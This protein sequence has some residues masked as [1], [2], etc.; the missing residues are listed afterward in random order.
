M[1]V[2]TSATA[3]I[4]RLAVW[5]L[6]HDGELYGDEQERLRWYEGIALTASIQ[7]IVVPW[8]LAVMAWIGGRAVAPYLLIAAVVFYL[9]ILLTNAYVTR[10]RVRLFAGGWTRKRIVIS[11]LSGLPYVVLVIGLARAYDGF[12]DP[13]MV[14]SGAVGALIGLGA[15]VIGFRRDS[16][17][18]AA[19]G[20]DDE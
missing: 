13:A 14:I 15:V 19:A 18:A 3:P 17:R 2:N 5:L 4:D 9:P 7:W 6:D 8:A 20:P 10:W 12:D 1:A 11:V 16:R